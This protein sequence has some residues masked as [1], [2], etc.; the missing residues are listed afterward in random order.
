MAATTITARKV[1]EV[2]ILDIVGP[3]KMGDAEESFRE[4]VRE[5]LDGGDRKLAI[6]L[7]SVPEMDSSGIGAL[8][9]THSAAKQA[10]GRCRLFGAPK[11]VRQTLRMV[12]L[13]SV[14]DLVEDENTAL[15]GF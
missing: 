7:T 5:F 14:L 10:G 3:L 13:D 9:R 1:G 6:N 8:V 15:S 2:T 11:R 12:R 4:R